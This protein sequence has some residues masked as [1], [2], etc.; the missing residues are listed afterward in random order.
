VPE[1][2]GHQAG[3]EEALVLL[4]DQ[5]DVADRRQHQ[6]HD[7]D[8]ARLGLEGPSRQRGQDETQRRHRL[9]GPDEGAALL[10]FGEDQ[11]DSADRG[12]DSEGRGG[13]AASL[14]RIS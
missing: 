12:E 11:T 4:G 9:G 7:H 10:G 3:E 14:P 1:Q 8:A 2:E 6:A 13:H 5:E